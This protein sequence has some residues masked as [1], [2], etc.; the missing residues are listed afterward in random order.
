VNSMHELDYYPA[1]R[2][3]SATT[4]I[5]VATGSVAA[6]LFILIAELPFLF[7]NEYYIFIWYNINWPLSYFIANN[8]GLGPSHWFRLALIVC[9]N[10]VAWG[11][12]VA[13]FA[14]VACRIYRFMFAS[15]RRAR[16]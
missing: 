6:I 1:Q 7:M 3:M 14:Y 11:V 8:F 4:K 12:I 5:T 16:H 15:K 2:R 10:A 9:C 13:G